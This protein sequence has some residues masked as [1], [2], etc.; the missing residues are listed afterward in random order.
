MFKFCWSI[1]STLFACRHF[2]SFSYYSFS[3]CCCFFFGQND[4]NRACFIKILEV[5]GRYVSNYACIV[6]RSLFLYVHSLLILFI[7]SFFLCVVCVSFLIEM[8]GFLIKLKTHDTKHIEVRLP[9]NNTNKTS[10]VIIGSNINK[11]NERSCK[12]KSNKWIYLM[13]TYCDSWMARILMCGFCIVAS[14]TGCLVKA[15]ILYGKVVQL[16]G[17]KMFEDWLAESQF[18]LPNFFT[19]FEICV[20]RFQSFF[21]VF[22]MLLRSIKEFEDIRNSNLRSCQLT[23]FLWIEVDGIRA[24]SQFALLNSDKN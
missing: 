4:R 14:A 11:N 23:F 17:K 7:L 15:K 24:C 22:F 20:L 2:R 10:E 21:V 5:Y 13:T 19:F 16:G 12:W 6:S 8:K 1:A 9:K 3:C 18:L